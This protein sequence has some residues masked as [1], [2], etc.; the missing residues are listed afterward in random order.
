MGTSERDA[1]AEVVAASCFAHCGDAWAYL[2]H[3]LDS[4]VRGDVESAV[5][6]TYYAELRAALSLLATE[7]LVIGDRAQACVTFDGSVRATPSATRP[8]STHQ[9]IWPFLDR[10]SRTPASSEL[11]L[12]VVAPGLACLDQWLSLPTSGTSAV[13]VSK[14]FAELSLDLQS[15]RDDRTRRNA[16]SYNPSRIAP[17]DMDPQEVRDLA[18][19]IL[20]CLEPSGAG[21]FPLV[22]QVISR[23]VIIDL[24]NGLTGEQFGEDGEQLPRQTLAEWLDA[25]TAEGAIGAEVLAELAK[26]PGLSRYDIVLRFQAVAATASPRSALSG[27]LARGLILAR[28]ATGACGRLLRDAD[29]DSSHLEHWI[30]ALGLARGFW[31]PKAE[32]ESRLDLWADIGLVRDLIAGAA[33]TSINEVIASAEVQ[34]PVIGQTE[35]VVAWS[36]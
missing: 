29:L 3:A 10:W 28:L 31:E 21:T 18:V 9:A 17:D 25:N 4:V 15:M 20:S 12:S 23:S 35:R 13:A 5:H 19:T 26:P 1:F 24:Y 16:A 14:L 2:G 22:D 32:P 36:F 27:M 11:V 30:D 34:F 33:G 6:F 8:A 7:G